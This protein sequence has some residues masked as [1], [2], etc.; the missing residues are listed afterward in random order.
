MPGQ[1]LLARFACKGLR[2]ASEEPSL[3]RTATCL[4]EHLGRISARDVLVGPL[5]KQDV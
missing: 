2:E 3:R 4:W 1:D 5:G